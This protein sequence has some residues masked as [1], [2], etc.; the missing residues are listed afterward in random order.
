[1]EKELQSLSDEELQAKTPAFMD[2]VEK[3]ESLED[4][5]PEAFAVVKNAARRMSGRTIEV[6]EQP[7]L[8]E[9]VHYDDS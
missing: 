5:L 9:M 6:C 8:W 3:G 4:I 2:R 1:M 7:I